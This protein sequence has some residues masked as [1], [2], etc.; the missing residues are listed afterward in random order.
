MN[1]NTLRF[2][3]ARAAV[4]SVVIAAAAIYA[5]NARAETVALGHQADQH[6]LETLVALRTAPVDLLSNVALSALIAPTL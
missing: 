6:T 4:L 5:G 2:G 1:T 3:V